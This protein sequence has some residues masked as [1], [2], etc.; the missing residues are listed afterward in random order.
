MVF[1]PQIVIK[2]FNIMKLYII[3]KK[4]VTYVT[5]VIPLI[6]LVEKFHSKFS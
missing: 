5:A 2:L 1:G 6:T 4:I 3:S